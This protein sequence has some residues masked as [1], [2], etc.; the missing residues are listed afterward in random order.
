[1]DSLFPMWQYSAN[2]QGLVLLRAHASLEVSG[3]FSI[4]RRAGKEMLLCD[5]GRNLC[6]KQTCC[7]CTARAKERFVLSVQK[8]YGMIPIFLEMGVVIQVAFLLCSSFYWIWFPL[9]VCSSV[10]SPM[11]D[12][13]SFRCSDFL[14]Q[15]IVIYWVYWLLPKHLHFMVYGF[16]CIWQFFCETGTG[17]WP[18]KK[19]SN[20]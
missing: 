13:D 16:V 12:W 4:P 15:Y 2:H 9:S 5:A 20:I 1:M 3:T 6:L 17:V 19:V 11:S 7:F 10:F 8:P 14:P 18:M